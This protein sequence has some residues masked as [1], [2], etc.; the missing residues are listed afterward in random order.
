MVAQQ[1]HRRPCCGCS[2]GRQCP[3]IQIWQVSK[4]DIVVQR[5][6]NVDPS[7][8]RKATQSATRACC[9]CSCH[10]KHARRVNST[11]PEGPGYVDP[12][13]PHSVHIDEHYN[14]DMRTLQHDQA[15]NLRRQASARAYLHHISVNAGIQS[16]GGAGYDS[17]YV[18]RVSNRASYINQPQCE[19]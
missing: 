7:H 1:V 16:H 2:R 19:R 18:L 11:R 13:G 14:K 17:P 4:N 3:L 15:P 8:T 12:R 5:T 10:D 6:S 9:R